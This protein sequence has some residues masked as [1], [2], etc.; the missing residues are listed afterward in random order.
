[1]PFNQIKKSLVPYYALVSFGVAQSVKNGKNHQTS[2]FFKN[3]KRGETK[4]WGQGG[5]FSKIY[6]QTLES[7]KHSIPLIHDR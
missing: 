5:T 6:P 1:M 3:I 4:M 7:L 2:P